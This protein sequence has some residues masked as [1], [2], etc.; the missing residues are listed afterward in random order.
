MLELRSGYLWIQGQKGAVDTVLKTSNSQITFKKVEGIV[1]Y[2]PAN[3]KSQILAISG[4][5]DIANIEKPILAERVQ[6][7]MF[8]FVLSPPFAKIIS[9]P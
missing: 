3:E 9:C 1:S 4:H 5:F 8:S 6:S 2:D 7:G